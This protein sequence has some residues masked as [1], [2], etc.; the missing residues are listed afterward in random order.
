MIFGL[1]FMIQTDLRFSMAEA[2]SFGAPCI[3]Q[4]IYK[5]AHSLT[6]IHAASG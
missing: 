6:S 4:K 2:K 1:P 5:S 3:I